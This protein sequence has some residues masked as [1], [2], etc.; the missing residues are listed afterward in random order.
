[1]KLWALWL[2]LWETVIGDLVGASP[3]EKNLTAVCI[4]AGHA[5]TAADY[6]NQVRS[7]EDT[8]SHVKPHVHR[9]FAITFTFNP[10]S[11]PPQSDNTQHNDR[12]YPTMT[13]PP[14][15][16]RRS[17]D[18]NGE[19]E[20][21]KRGLQALSCTGATGQSTQPFPPLASHLAAI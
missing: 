1:M 18:G 19:C 3:A 14:G 17:K 13:R 9:G 6:H 10:T 12:H 20:T 8:R 5:I 4:T 15:F 2:R 7:L 11:S 21:E 16:L